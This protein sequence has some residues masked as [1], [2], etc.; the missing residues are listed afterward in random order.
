MGGF[1][2]A[3]RFADGKAAGTWSVTGDRARVA[4]GGFVQHTKAGARVSATNV[5]EWQATWTAPER[6]EVVFNVAGNASNNDASP[7][8]D[9][10]YVVELKSAAA[11]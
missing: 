5:N 2:L 10:I 8:G 1:Q 3:A 11:R 6:G 9:F 7:L 4:S